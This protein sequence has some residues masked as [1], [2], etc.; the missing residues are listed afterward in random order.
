[1]NPPVTQ[2]NVPWEKGILHDLKGVTSL[3][4]ALV[5]GRAYITR[6]SPQNGGPHAQT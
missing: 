6:E 5:T 3:R 1:M 2:P 4:I